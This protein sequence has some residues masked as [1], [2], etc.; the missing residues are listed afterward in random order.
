MKQPL[1]R[2]RLQ[3]FKS[4]KE[5]DVAFG[6]LNVLIG[7]NGSGKSN[8]LSLFRLI[9]QMLTPG[10]G[11]QLHVA[12]NGGAEAFL[13][14]GRR[15]TSQIDLELY[16]GANR[17]RAQWQASVD[18]NLVFSSEVAEFKMVDKQWFNRNLGS[19]HRESRLLEEAQH[20]VVSYVLK[21]MQSWRV[22]HFH[23]TSDNAAVKLQNNLNDNDYLRTDAANL[24][25]FLYWLQQGYPNH[26]A[27]IVEAVRLVFP[28][29][30]DFVL[31]PLPANP[32]QVRLEWRERGSDKLFLPYQLSDG[33][34]RF[35]CL[36]TALLQPKLPATIV[37]DEPE[38]GLHPYALFLLN[39]LLQ[40]AATQTQLILAT[41]STVLLSYFKPQE[42]L[43]LDRFEG[44]SILKRLDADELALWLEDYSLG[45]LWE[46][47]LF[48][49]RP[50]P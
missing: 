44:Q 7:S 18:D 41:Q 25:P 22:Y 3:G 27:Q 20:S 1:E 2:L 45:V 26:Y 10:L 48:G 29:F 28:T 11:L 24:G 8:L 42:V 49:G 12:K 46:K 9:W 14:Y 30:D 39:E 4:F 17:Y 43:V 33:T 47:N 23:D 37:I 21:G 34:L 50:T 35:M 32:N 19:G 13:H 40:K 15:N 6:P 38:L 16:F 5:L 36:A 31:R